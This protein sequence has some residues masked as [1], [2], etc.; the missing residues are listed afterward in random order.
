[1]E[2]KSLGCA[3]EADEMRKT[4]W[5]GAIFRDDNEVTV[6]FWGDESNFSR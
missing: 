1:M 4:S 5:Q 6:I 3:E 2:W